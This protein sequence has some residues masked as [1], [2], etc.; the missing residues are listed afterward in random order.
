MSDI[1]D[2]LRRAI[3]RSDLS[4]YQL[5]KDSG[6]AAIMIGRFV[7]GE[8]DIRLATAD[9][10][11]SALGVRVAVPARRRSGRGRR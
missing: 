6:V 4:V 11:A 3:E 9:K 10:L 7:R 1:S 8:R 2:A 5:A